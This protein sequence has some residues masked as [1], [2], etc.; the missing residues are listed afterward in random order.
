M[1]REG[2]PS[3]QRSAETS[4][5]RAAVGTMTE[6]GSPGSDNI[7]FRIYDDARPASSQ[8]QTPQNLPESRHRSRLLGTYTAPVHG[9][10]SSISGLRGR[11]WLQRRQ[12]R[13]TP[14][15]E[16]LD[17]PGFQGLY[18]GLENSD[19][20]TLYELAQGRLGQTRRDGPFSEPDN[21]A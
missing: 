1:H 3:G 7:R 11:S 14:S 17:T 19:D 18:G 9:S 8:P 5:H 4:E 6:A 12:G 16:G 15:P 13:R 2:D 21:D 10:G 20:L